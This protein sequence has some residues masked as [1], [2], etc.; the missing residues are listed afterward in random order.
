MAAPNP[1]R[2]SCHFM[3][4]PGEIHL[5]ILQ[6]AVSS[7]LHWPSLAYLRTTN[8]Y[9]ANLLTKKEFNEIRE[10]II[11][12]QTPIED[13]RASRKP[14]PPLWNIRFLCTSC[15]MV[16]PPVHFQ[17]ET[18]SNS[19][20]HKNGRRRRC[21]L[22]EIR[23]RVLNNHKII[24]MTDC[25]GDVSKK[26]LWVW[27]EYGWSVCWECGGEECMVIEH[28]EGMPIAK[29]A[30]LSFQNCYRFCSR[31]RGCEKE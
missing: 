3:S 2:K 10:E 26:E 29:K 23:K 20:W 8:A 22:C 24:E 12:E 27:H 11:Q 28:K 14:E 9:F 4:L 7:P 17:Y 13:Y 31:Q 6:Y 16:L 1:I 21:I 19:M 18:L 15:M 25:L 30:D 5:R